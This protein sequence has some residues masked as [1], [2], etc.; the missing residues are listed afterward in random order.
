MNLKILPLVEEIKMYSNY[1]TNNLKHYFNP[2][3]H[4]RNIRTTYLYVNMSIG[5][6]YN[7]INTQ[8][9]YSNKVGFYLI[10]L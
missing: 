3:N 10:K 8:V 5:G 7:P 6:K 1:F 2:I 9:V 4:N